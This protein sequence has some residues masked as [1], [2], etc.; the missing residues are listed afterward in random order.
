MINATTLADLRRQHWEFE[1]S[2]YDG[3]N[4][5]S[6]ITTTGRLSIRRRRRSVH[7]ALRRLTAVYP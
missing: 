7:R 6:G 3:H 4:R 1:R 5:R 2:G